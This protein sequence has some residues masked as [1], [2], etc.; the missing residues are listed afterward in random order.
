MSLLVFFFLM[1]FQSLDFFSKAEKSLGFTKEK[2]T[3]RFAI[4]QRRKFSCSSTGPL[5]GYM[6]VPSYFLNTAEPFEQVLRLGK[7]DKS[8]QSTNR[9]RWNYLL[10][11][12]NCFTGKYTTSKIHPKLYL[13]PEWYVFHSEDIDYL[14]SHFF[15]VVCANS[16]FVSVIK[17]KLH[18]GLK[19]WM[20]FCS[21]KSNNGW[22]PYTIYVSY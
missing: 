7:I 17:W 10:Y 4:S 1:P 8:G 3:S 20:L 6:Y 21:V 14:V 16:Q 11:R 22:Y 19:I 2:P 5:S 15:T 13:G 12:H 18:I 9:G